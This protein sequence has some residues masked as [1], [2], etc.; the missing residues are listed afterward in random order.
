MNTHHIRN[1]PPHHG[2]CIYFFTEVTIGFSQIFYQVTEG[3]NTT[4]NICGFL[5]NSTGIWKS[6]L[7]AIIALLP[8]TATGTIAFMCAVR[9]DGLCFDVCA[10]LV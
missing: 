1:N 4:L 10:F 8:S 6:N 7:S 3:T 5:N 9:C 2:Q